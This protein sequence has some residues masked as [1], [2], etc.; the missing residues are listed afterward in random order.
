MMF[1]YNW[2][3][4]RKPREKQRQKRKQLLERVHQ[5]EGLMVLKETANVATLPNLL[6]LKLIQ[7]REGMRNTVDTP[8]ISHEHPMDRKLLI[9][10]R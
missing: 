2:Y 9:L 3:N 8:I 7:A 10:Q 1:M 4:S 5:W 6:Y